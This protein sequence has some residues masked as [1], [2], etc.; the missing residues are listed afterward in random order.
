MWVVYDPSLKALVIF[1]CMWIKLNISGTFVVSYVQAIE[2]FPTSVRQSGIGF[3]TLISQTIS[4][5]GPYV[6]YLGAT[7][8]K[9]PYLIMFLVCFAGATAVSLLPETLGARL[10]ET[11]EEASTF[12]AKDKFFSYLPRRKESEDQAAND[13]FEKQEKESLLDWNAVMKDVVDGCP[14]KTVD[15][16]LVKD[17]LKKHYDGLPEENV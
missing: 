11:L 14:G 6:I 4:I 1:L 16:N 7:D 15:P 13:Y 17:L 10:P 2:L 5:G 3:A 9:L 8:L 12:G